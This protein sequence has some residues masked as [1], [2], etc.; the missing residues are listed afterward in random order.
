MPRLVD[1]DRRRE[2]LCDAVV[3][4]VVSDGFSAVTFRSVAAHIGASTTVVSHYVATRDEL[5]L[6]ATCR[7]VQR[8]RSALTAQLRDSRSAA[9]VRTLVEWCVI[10]SGWSA[11]RFWL[12]LVVASDTEPVARDQL[13]AFNAWWDEL[14]EGLVRSDGAGH[15][16]AAVV[17]D[18]IGVLVDGLVMSALLPDRGLTERRRRAV[19]DAWLGEL[20]RTHPRVEAASEASGSDGSSQHPGS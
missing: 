8:R 19:I 20:A 2:A 15:E 9:G 6:M 1:P 3:D 13:L 14:V 7:E 16:D 17:V 5:V 4:I 18:S 11:Q 12:A 10:G